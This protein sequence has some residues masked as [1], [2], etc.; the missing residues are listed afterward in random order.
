MKIVWGSFHIFYFCIKSFTFQLI[1]HEKIEMHQTVQTFYQK[2]LLKYC[3]GKKDFAWIKTM[4]YARKGY[5]IFY[6]MY[7]SFS[8]LVPSGFGKVHFNP[9]KSMVNSF[10]F[11]LFFYYG[12]DRQCIVV[13]KMSRICGV[14]ISSVRF[15]FSIFIIFETYPG[16][17]LPFNA[18]L[19]N[20]R[21]PR[22]TNYFWCWH[23]VMFSILLQEKWGIY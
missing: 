7:I 17:T 21:V 23:F 9:A 4:K 5:N 18:Q 11:F 16:N 19:F 1:C 3:N 10:F 22:E 6:Y 14:H 13:I 2:N 20:K 15:I 8:I 12:L